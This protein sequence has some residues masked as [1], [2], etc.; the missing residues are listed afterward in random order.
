MSIQS[1]G[2]FNHAQFTL[3]KAQKIPFLAIGPAICKIVL[4]IAQI[5]HGLAMTL[6]YSIAFSATKVESHLSKAKEYLKHAQD[7]VENLGWGIANLLSF[8][9]AN[10]FYQI[11][12]QS[13]NNIPQTLSAPLLKMTASYIFEN[14]SAITP[15]KLIELEGLLAG[16][17]QDIE[18]IN[19]MSAVAKEKELD[20]TKCTTLKEIL[21]LLKEEVSQPLI[22]LCPQFP[23]GQEFLESIKE[24]SRFEQAQQIDHWISTNPAIQNIESLGLPLELNHLPPVIFDLKQLKLLHLNMLEVEITNLELGTQVYKGEKFMVPIPTELEKGNQVYKEKCKEFLPMVNLWRES[25]DYYNTSA[26]DDALV[27]LA[28]EVIKVRNSLD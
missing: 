20:I 10:Q 3:T 21:D 7:G 19:I 28:K 4:S 2:Q 24:L 22:K 6:F 26:G 15:Q 1:I 25:I 13:D 18:A 12:N 23:Q 14:P 11:E 9:A 27:N 5:L 8:G 16:L 17:G